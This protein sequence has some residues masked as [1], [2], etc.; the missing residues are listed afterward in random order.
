MPTLC[1][2]RFKYKSEANRIFERGF[3][4]GYRDRVPK[5]NDD[6]NYV[7]GYRQGELRRRL[8]VM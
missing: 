1:V 5:Y 4:D 7:A 2:E 8:D 3:Q 6:T